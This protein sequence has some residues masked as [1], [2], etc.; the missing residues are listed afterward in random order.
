MM[1]ETTLHLLNQLDSKNSRFKMII[2]S[3]K[4]PTRIA[5]LTR[6]YPRY[7]IENPKLLDSLLDF[8]YNAHNNPLLFQDE[9]TIKYLWYL[10]FSGPP[11]SQRKALE[12]IGMVNKDMKVSDALITYLPLGEFLQVLPAW[13]RELRILVDF[14]KTLTAVASN[15]EKRLIDK[16]ILHPN[17][18]P[19][20]MSFVDHLK[21][22]DTIK[23]KDLHVGKMIVIN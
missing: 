6:N 21:E 12:I 13:K 15:L 20:L 3:L 10:T 19:E 16:A 23:S 7:T 4:L 11:T 14:L 2:Q 22:D 5:H 9:S 8:L 18:I 17:L 1:I